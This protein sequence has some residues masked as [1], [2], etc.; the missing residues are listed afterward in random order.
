ML[1]KRQS[2]ILTPHSQK[3]Y[4]ATYLCSLERDS[5]LERVPVEDAEFPGTSQQDLLGCPLQELLLILRTQNPQCK[6]DT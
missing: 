6:E 5:S 1:I 4:R 2:K 3:Q